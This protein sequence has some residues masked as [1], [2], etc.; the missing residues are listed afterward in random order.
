MEVND[1]ERRTRLV[2]CR[3][4]GR[5]RLAMPASQIIPWIWNP[6]LG[7]SRLLGLLIPVP[8]AAQLIAALLPTTGATC[9]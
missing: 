1:S 5:D 3:A 4:G 8:A 2:I 6:V 9:Q 7:G